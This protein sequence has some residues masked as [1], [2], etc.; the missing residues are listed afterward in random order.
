MSR[1][2]AFLIFAYAPI[3]ARHLPFAFDERAC[4]HTG[5]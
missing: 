5:S 2:I 3:A 4:R 1:F